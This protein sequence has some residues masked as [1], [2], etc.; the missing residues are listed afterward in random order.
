[1]RSLNRE[2]SLQDDLFRT[3]LLMHLR[4][5]A[6]ILNYVT[7]TSG[8]RQSLFSKTPGK[9]S[10]TRLKFHHTLLVLFFEE[11]KNNFFLFFHRFND[12]IKYEYEEA[13]GPNGKR[14]FNEITNC[15][16][17]RDTSTKVRETVPDGHVLAII[18]SSDETQLTNKTN[19]HN[20]YVSLAIVDRDK[21]AKDFGRKVSKIMTHFSKM[22]QAKK[23]F[24]HAAGCPNS[25]P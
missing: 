13:R 4:F 19:V 8:A 10:Q 22:S 3:G 24:L 20:V 17:F 11:K 16:W 7:S 9:S 15:D 12:H 5:R 23:Q 6:S 21:R 1:V 25:T 18:L 2:N 14:I